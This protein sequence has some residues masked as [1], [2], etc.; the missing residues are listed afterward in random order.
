MQRLNKSRRFL[1]PSMNRNY[2][3]S[4]TNTQANFS[5][6]PLRFVIIRHA[7]RIDAV[8]GSDWSRKSF[9]RL[10]RYVRFS[11]HLPN[12]FVEE[13]S[14]REFLFSF[15]SSFSLPCRSYLHHYVIDVPLSN[16][17]RLQS[18]QTGRT[19]SLNDCNVDFCYTS[20]SL[21]CVQTADAILLGMQRKLVP[22]KIVCIFHHVYPS[23]Y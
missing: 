22:M 4:P 16:R 12:T 3:D 15:L 23:L 11:E 19:L 14:N 1:S 17:A 13:K 8:L 20:P 2:H 7:E 9:D 6:K 18:L 5:T 21:R 10:G